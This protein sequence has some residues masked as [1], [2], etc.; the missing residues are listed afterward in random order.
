MKTQYIFPLLLF[1][2]LLILQTTVIPLFAL[3]NA[4]PDLIL[5]LLAFYAISYGQIYG[6][7]L[8]FVYGF[9]FDLITGSLLG[10]AMLSKTI[11]GFIAGYFSNEN[12]RDIYLRSYVFSFIVLMCAVVDSIVYSFFSTA[13]LQRNFLLLFFE[14]GFLPGLYTAVISII[15]VIFLPGRRFF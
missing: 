9:L 8:G 4:V 2:P 3:F 7:I 15:V 10:S 1:I 13:D 11:A 12:K 14:Q 6:T 5:I